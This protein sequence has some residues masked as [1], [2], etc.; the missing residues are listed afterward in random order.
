M[1]MPSADARFSVHNR[2]AETAPLA[3]SRATTGRDVKHTKVKPNIFAA[4]GGVIGM[5]AKIEG[6]RKK[7]R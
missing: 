6:G 3:R 1:C 5:Q 2:K 4:L 7:K